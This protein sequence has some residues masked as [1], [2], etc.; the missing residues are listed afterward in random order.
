MVDVMRWRYGD[1]N[2]I[3]ARVDSDTVIE[4][5]DLLYLD[6]DDAKPA[7]DFPWAGSLAATQAAF[8]SQFLGVATQRSGVGQTE[9]IR[10]ATSGVFDFPVTRASLNE[11][12]KLAVAKAAGDSLLSQQVVEATSSAGTIGTAVRGG[13]DQTIARLRIQSVI[14]TGGYQDPVS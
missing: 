12:A 3:Q 6:T 2:P 8:Q 1:C 7:A 5:G 4:I 9:D 11:G 13:I 10:V 14:M